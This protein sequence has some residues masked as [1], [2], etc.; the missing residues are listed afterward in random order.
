LKFEAVGTY[1]NRSKNLMAMGGLTY[2]FGPTYQERTAEESTA[3]EST[4]S[5]TASECEVC[6]EPQVKEVVTIEEKIVYIPAPVPVKSDTSTPLP[7]DIEFKSNKASLTDDS[8]ESIRKY[9]EHLNTKAN[10]DKKLFIV[11][12]TDSTGSTRYNATLSIKRANAVR[13]EFISNNVD[14][15]RISVDGLGELNPV[16]DNTTKEGRKKNRRVIVIVNTPQ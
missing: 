3:V 1:A 5:T 4:A 2:K 9:S 14:P 7:L 13:S 10:Q 16:A 12:N 15:S 11:G 6:P 8:K